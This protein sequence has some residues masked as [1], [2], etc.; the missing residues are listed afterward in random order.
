VVFDLALATLIV[1]G[2]IYVFLRSV[3][4]TFIPAVTVPIALI[5]TIAAIYAAGFSINILTL[6]A[7]VLATG[8]VVDDAI[9]V[10]RTSRAS[11]RSLGPRAAAVL[12]TR[13]VFF[14]VL[15][16]TVTLAA[17][18]IPISFFPGTA[19]R[20]FSEFGFVLAF[21]V[22]LS[23]FVALT[24]VPMLASRWIGSGH[25]APSR[26]PIG[27]A[28]SG[29]GVALERLYARLLDASLNAPIGDHRA[30][31]FAGAA[32]RLPASPQPAHPVEPRLHPD[33]IRAAR[34]TSTTPP[35]GSAGEAIV[36][37]FHDRGEIVNVF[38]TA[39]GFGGGGFMFVTLAPW[40]ERTR[41]QQ[42]ITA[43]LN[44]RLQ[45]IPGIS[46]TAFTANSLGIRGGGQ[47]LQFAVTGPI[48]TR[49]GRRDRPAPGDGTTSLRLRPPRTTP[50]SRMSIWSTA[51]RCRCR[52]AG[53]EHIGGDQT[54]LG[55]A[56]SA[57]STSA[58]ARDLAPWRRKDD[59]DRAGL[60]PIARTESGGWCSL[61]G[62]L[63]GGGGRAEPPAPGPA[64][65]GADV[66]DARARD[67]PSRGDG[68][69][70]RDCGGGAPARHGYP[71][72]RRGE[73]AEP[74]IERRRPDLRVCAPRRP[75]RARGAVRELRQRRHPDR[76]GALRAPRW[77]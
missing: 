51:P 23:A 37:E 25:H 45:E 27:R 72:H 74:G 66:G 19:G 52:R 75:P 36:Q 13:L 33:P 48:T 18:F 50:P 67:R 11:A 58:T 14:A 22:T 10:I 21:S 47:G 3:R 32:G 20:L 6:L 5:G 76:H 63:R 54:L 69:G 43:D 1:I 73:G 34:A 62:Q 26:N 31:L 77:C 61:A 68:P 41:T 8:L 53:P 49:C 40:D 39:Q 42:E 70:H 15:S 57:P 38:A 64:P 7:L 12:G 55:A 65:F 30:L 28:V 9:V 17:V 56:I 44:R 35:G 2:I 24:L 4:I 16:T 29:F 71:V 46:V 59:Q 60:D